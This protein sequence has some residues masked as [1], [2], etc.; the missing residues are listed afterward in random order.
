M[1]V[2]QIRKLRLKKLRNLAKSIPVRASTGTQPPIS[3]PDT[4]VNI[5]RASCVLYSDVSTSSGP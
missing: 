4:F 1:S 3:F 5:S 2:L